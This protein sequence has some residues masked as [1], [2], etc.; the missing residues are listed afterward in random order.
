MSVRPFMTAVL[1]TAAVLVIAS[2][3]VAGPAGGSHM[4]PGQ[5]E[6]TT[7]FSMPGTPVQIPPMVVSVCLSKDD[8]K[9]PDKT[10]PKPGSQCTFTDYQSDEK[11]VSWNMKCG[12]QR[13]MTG[14]GLIVFTGDSYEGTIHMTISGNSRAQ[15]MNMNVKAKRTGDCTK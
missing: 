5:W 11:K 1:A 4:K 8:V 9:D 13:P 2:S 6:T 7:T 10:L 14:R 12:G 3:L 15:E